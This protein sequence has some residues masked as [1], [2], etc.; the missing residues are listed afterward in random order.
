MA[1]IIEQGSKVDTIA[2]MVVTLLFGFMLLTVGTHQFIEKPK[3]Y[4]EAAC[5]TFKSLPL[6]EVPARCVTKEGGFK[7]E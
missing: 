6:N 1:T 7:N 3:Q 5:N 4:Q 2:I